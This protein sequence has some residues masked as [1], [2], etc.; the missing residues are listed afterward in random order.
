MEG[1]VATYPTTY[2]RFKLP[3]QQYDELLKRL[4]RDQRLG[5]YVDD[6]VRYVYFD[7]CVRAV[8]IVYSFDYEPDLGLLIARMPTASHEFFKTSVAAV[9]TDQLRR[10]ANVGGAVGKF[11]AKIADRCLL[12]P[13]DL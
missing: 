2:L 9:I 4:Q 6:K 7:H 1:R 3:P 10:V 12:Q 11:A 13:G 8:L 5:G